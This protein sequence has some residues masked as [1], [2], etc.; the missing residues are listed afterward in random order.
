[1]GELANTADERTKNKD[2]RT[3][4]KKKIFLGIEYIIESQ[5]SKVKDQKLEYNYLR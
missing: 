4:N 1:M 3:K 2:E 5:R